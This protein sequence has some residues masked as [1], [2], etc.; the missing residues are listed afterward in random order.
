MALVDMDTGLLT[1]FDPLF[2][3]ILGKDLLLT[4]LT[5]SVSDSSETT[6]AAASWP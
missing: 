6:L 1:S 3:A 2:F 4:G 5:L